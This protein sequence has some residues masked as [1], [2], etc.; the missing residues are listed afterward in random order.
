MFFE[1]LCFSP[2]AFATRGCT[3]VLSHARVLLPPEVAQVAMI[4]LH[5][6]IMNILDCWIRRHMDGD[7]NWYSRQPSS[8]GLVSAAGVV[9]KIFI[10]EKACS[11]R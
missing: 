1:V 3:D 8:L 4:V 11:C 5:S 6:Y 2:C 9:M 10:C 7:I